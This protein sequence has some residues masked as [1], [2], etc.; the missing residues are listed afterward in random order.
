MPDHAQTLPVAFEDRL[1]PG[2]PVGVSVVGPASPSRRKTDSTRSTVFDI[3]GPMIVTIDGPA[4]TGK[5]SVAREVA[6]RL[7][8]DFLDTGAMYRAAAVVALDHGL[9]PDDPMQRDPAALVAKVAQSDIHFIW[10]NDPPTVVAFGVDVHKRIRGEVVTEVVSPISGIK[11]LRKLMVEK[12]RAIGTKHPRLV[13]EGRDQGSVVFPDAPVKI[14]LD[15]SA[16]VRAK[17]RAEQ[18]REEGEHV[19]DKAILAGIIARDRSDMTR[20]DGRLMCPDGAIRVDTSPMSKEEVIGTLVR[21][22]RERA[23]AP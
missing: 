14:Y 9:W 23:V 20:E 5:S 18:L 19:D 8:L 21:I 15:A 4:G 6:H 11:A 1:M 7:G 10:D 13:T 22:V 12:Q 16:E 17:R 3:R 2:M